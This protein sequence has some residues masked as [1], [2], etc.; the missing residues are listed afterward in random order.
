LSKPGADFLYGK[1]PRKIFPPKKSGKIK[2]F[3]GK[4]FEKSFPQQIPRK[5]M[6]EKSA[7]VLGHVTEYFFSKSANVLFKNN[8]YLRGAAVAQR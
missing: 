5:K 2:I 3:R 1:I 8:F 4:S 6:Y 7:P